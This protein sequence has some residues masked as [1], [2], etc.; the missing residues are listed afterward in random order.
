MDSQTSSCIRY[1]EH[2][3]EKYL[4]KLPPP[5]KGYQPKKMICDEEVHN[6]F[7]KR[8]V[9][10]E[11]DLKSIAEQRAQGIGYRTIA[12]QFNTTSTTIRNLSKRYG[13]KSPTC[14]IPSLKSEPV[15]SRP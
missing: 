9:W 5:E 13:F 14:Y 12:R 3:Y 7:N 15:A 2:I 10:T 4:S 8:Y 1:Y 11:A 6:Q